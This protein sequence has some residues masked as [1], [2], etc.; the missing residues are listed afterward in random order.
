M[1]LKSV[2]AEPLVERRD[3]T[4]EVLGTMTRLERDRLV[5]AHRS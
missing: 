2:P 5:K 1:T 4:L 3:S